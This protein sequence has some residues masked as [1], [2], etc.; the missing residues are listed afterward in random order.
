MVAQISQP[1]AK[2]P[3]Q[4]QD[5]LCNQLILASMQNNSED[6]QKQKEAACASVN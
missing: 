5:K 1:K 4:L 6:I 3:Q 2:T